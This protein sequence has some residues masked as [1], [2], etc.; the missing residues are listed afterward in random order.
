MILNPLFPLRRHIARLHVFTNYTQLALD[1]PNSPYIRAGNYITYGKSLLKSAETNNRDAVFGTET[2]PRT[3]LPE[4]LELFF[5]DACKMP[6]SRFEEL[7]IEIGDYYFQYCNVVADGMMKTGLYALWL[8][9]IG[10]FVISNIR[11]ASEILS[12]FSSNFLRLFLSIDM[13]GPLLTPQYSNYLSYF[14]NPA[15]LPATIPMSAV[16]AILMRINLAG[17]L[18]LLLCIEPSRHSFSF[19]LMRRQIAY[20]LFLQE[21]ILTTIS[22][23]WFVL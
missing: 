16:E 12:R 13:I 10:K 22:P 1:D 18:T 5:E 17:A 11:I 14:L 15:T 8:D 23:P 6:R 4:L 7:D 19:A 9:M 20:F 21:N 3:D 2:T